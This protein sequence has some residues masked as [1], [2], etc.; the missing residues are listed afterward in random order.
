MK[1][2]REFLKISAATVATA[3]ALNAGAF[4]FSLLKK[5]QPNLLFIFTDQQS[6]DMLGCYGN[7]QIQTPHLDRLASE[8]VRFEYCIS[9]SPVCTPM[10]AMLLSGQ[11]P[12][13][14]GAFTN[15]VNMFPGN[16]TYFAEV[17]NAHGYQTGYVGKWHV[18]GGNRNRPI[19]AGPYRY[20]F[21]D[22]F[23][24]NNCALQFNKG[25]YYDQFTGSKINWPVGDWE[26]DHQTA[27][28]VNFINQ[29]TPD[30]PWALFVSWHPPHDHDYGTYDAPAE[31]EALYPPETIALRPTMTDSPAIRSDMQGYMAM[32]TS[33]DA[34]VGQLMDQLRENGVEDDTIV[35]FTSDHGDL[36]GA[37]G[38]PWPK[39]C[40]ED[41]SCRVPLIIRYPE[42]LRPRSSELLVGTLDLMP[43]LLGLMNISSPSSC[44]GQNL[45]PHIFAE[46]DDAVQ[47]VP[48]FH[49]NPSWRGIFTRNFTYSENAGGSG[50]SVNF[51]CLYDRQAD[52]YQSVNRFDD[53]AW[54]AQQQQL[55]DE[56]QA[57][58]NRFEDPFLPEK[59]FI[60]LMGFPYPFAAGETGMLPARPLDLL[61][62]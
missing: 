24:S 29:S 5:K 6:F 42:K 59:T 32:C 55:K 56:M 22:A 35:V 54:A 40:P 23:L 31:L 2:R 33:C 57:W 53:S 39:G 50:T 51:N 26:V 11:H 49:Y 37:H 34:A 46:N 12:L 38:R 10:R 47:S 1:T 27:Q 52:P 17:L 15:D 58:L 20:G 21:D 19:P 44:D 7:Q 8:G 30:R 41:E 48:L 36:H 28:A 45:M 13:K 14:N 60:E 4:S 62:T 9:S 43:T 18:Y 16:G 3:P 61:K 25:F